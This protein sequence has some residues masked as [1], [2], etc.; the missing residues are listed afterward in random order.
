MEGSPAVKPP[1]YSGRVQR[2]PFTALAGV[3]DAIMADIEYPAWA[4]FILTYA[5]AEGL[6]IRDV[7]DLACG[8]GGLTR[9]LLARGLTVTGLDAS[10][11][12][13]AV[14][15]ARLPEVPFLRGDLRDFALPE[16]FDLITCVFDSLNNLTE[17]AELGLALSRMAAHLTP[18][19]LV[20]FDVNTRAGV[21]ELWDEDAIEGLAPLEGGGE[22]HYHWS[23]HYDP[24]RGLGVVQAL[25]RVGEEEFIEL[26][27][28]RG[29]D[30]A[31]LEPLLSAAGFAAWEFVEFPDYAPPEPGAP[32]V[33]VF[34]RGPV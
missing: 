8:T 9:S 6:E 14:A 13:L 11:E 2:P 15:R 7:L 24:A 22:V 19:G 21:R 25:C 10:E 1:P 28:E 30:Q 23:H 33:W 32:R 18:G 34:A 4:D 16:R 12:M 3:Y 31:D 5:R 20:A 29:Y 26:H 17:P 27:E